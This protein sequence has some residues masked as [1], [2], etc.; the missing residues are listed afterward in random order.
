MRSTVLT[1]GTSHRP[2]K[3][4]FSR[5][6][7]YSHIVAARIWADRALEFSWLAAVVLVPMITL[8]DS[9][10][11]ATVGPA[12]TATLR[13]IASVAVIAWL[14]H[15]VLWLTARS[16]FPVIEPASRYCRK[17]I[18][19]RESKALSVAAACLADSQCRHTCSRYAVFNVAVD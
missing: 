8:P 15:G 16:L 17:Q 4:R 2:D 19:F 11:V 1:A 5:H 3:R 12:K 9:A 13:I 18:V 14:L 6:M 7:N 10:F